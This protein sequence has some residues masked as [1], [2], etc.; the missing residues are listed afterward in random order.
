MIDLEVYSIIAEALCCSSDMKPTMSLTSDLFMCETGLRT[1][2]SF[3]NDDFDLSSPITN[4]EASQW[5]TTG[6]VVAAVNRRMK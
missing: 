6:D 5:S 3:L 1:I 2:V 4:L